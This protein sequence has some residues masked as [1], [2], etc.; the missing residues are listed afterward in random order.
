M[1]YSAVTQPC[2]FPRRNGGTFSSTD[3][4][5]I[6]FVLPVQIK[7]EP[8]A[9]RT[10]SVSIVTGR[11]ISGAL[12]SFRVSISHF[13]RY[14]VLSLHSFDALRVFP[15]ETSAKIVD[16]ASKFAL[17]AFLSAHFVVCLE[18]RVC[19]PAGKFI[20]KDLFRG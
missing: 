13:L 12:P 8:S 5:Q 2:P 18:A 1:A 4:V 11:P 7:H 3:V 20:R 17:W 16:S 10:K 14:S 9:V 15:A 6:T 19:I